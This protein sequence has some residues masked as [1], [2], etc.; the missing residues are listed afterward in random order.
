MR[1]LATLASGI[2]FLSALGLTAGCGLFGFLATP[3]GQCVN[4]AGCPEGQTCWA[5][6]CIGGAVPECLDDSECPAGW[7]CF[8]G[9][10][11]EPETPEC[12]T[13]ADCD[14]DEV[15]ENGACVAAPPDAECET[16]ADC[17]ADEVCENGA[18]VAA[19][20]DAEC[21]T[22]ADCEE[23]EVCDNGACVA[24]PPEAECET[25]ADCAEGEVC[26]NGEC[27]DVGGVLDGALLYAENCAACH[28]PNGNDGFATDITGLSAE[29]LAA[30]LESPSHAGI[31]LTDEEI[32][33]IA[34]F[35]AL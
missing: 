10:C 4:D 30:G 31:E 27:I 21:E 26:D 33:A 2:A 23:G 7:V 35:L 3:G 6:Q 29:E 20:P 9:V 22:D 25:D 19:P 14:A 11:R 16:D 5:N 24:A 13:D 28:G 34:D 18:C 8:S 12:E 17:D 15:C 32:A 1:R